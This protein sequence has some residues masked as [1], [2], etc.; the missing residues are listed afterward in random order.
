MYA[1]VHH[2]TY[3]QILFVGKDQEQGIAQLIL[4]EHA[5]EFLPRLDNTISV[6]GVDHEN[7]ALRVLEV[8]PPKR[9]NL[10]LTTNVPNRKLDILVLNSLDIES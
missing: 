5:L 8:M 7:D 6:V 10:I 2:K 9:S 3:G 1:S 4:I